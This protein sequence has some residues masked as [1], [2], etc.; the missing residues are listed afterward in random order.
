MK[1][2]HGLAVEHE[3][4]ATQET[5]RA[6]SDDSPNIPQEWSNQTMHVYLEKFSMNDLYHHHHHHHGIHLAYQFFHSKS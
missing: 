2:K 5:Q 4:R 3:L 1:R 6:F